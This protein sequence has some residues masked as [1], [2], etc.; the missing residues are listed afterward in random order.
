MVAEEFWGGACEL[1]GAVQKES[2]AIWV[3]VPRGRGMFERQHIF[4]GRVEAAP[5]FHVCRS[6]GVHYDYLEL[7][8]AELH[9]AITAQIATTLPASGSSTT[10]ALLLAMCGPLLAAS[11]GLV[12]MAF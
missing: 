2:V 12:A 10:T 7:Q 4:C 6:S 9:D 1:A 5:K 11:S 3:W 8:D